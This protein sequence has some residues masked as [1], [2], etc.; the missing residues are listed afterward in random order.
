MGNVKSDF[1]RAVKSC[2]AKYSVFSGRS[3]RSEYWYW[4]LFVVACSAAIFPLDVWLFDA[5]TNDLS[6]QYL[7]NAFTLLTLAP[8]L[9]VG[10]RRL[11]DIDRSGWWILLIF[12]LVGI[13]VIVYWACKEGTPGNNRFGPNPKMH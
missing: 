5:S 8:S 11:H 9:A 4:T 3:T 2:V 6:T 7:N 10:I 1:L 13:V 12:T